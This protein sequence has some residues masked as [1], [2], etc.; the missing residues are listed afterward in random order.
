M[1]KLLVFVS[2]Y[3]KPQWRL[4]VIALLTGLIAASASGLGIPLMF[5]VVFP[6]IFTGIEMLP[7]AIQPY[8]E[9]RSEQQILLGTCLLM[10]AVFILRGL[11][12]W[13][14]SIVVN[15]LA[16]RVLT[17]MRMSFFTRLHHLPIA[18]FEGYQKGD[19]ISRVVGDAA[20]VQI[21]MTTISNDIVKQPITCL[22]ALVAFFSLLISQGADWTFALNIFFVA[23]ALYPIISFGRRIAARSHKAQA[24]IGNLN[25]LVQQN[26]EMQREVRAY[27]MESQQVADFERVSDRYATNILKLVKYQKALL[28][29]METVT[30]LALAFLLV[31][32]KLAGMNYYDFMALAAALFF[33]FDSMKKTGRSF[34][35]FNEAQG[36]IARLSELLELPN[37]MPEPE[38]PLEM[39]DVRGDIDFKNASF[40]YATGEVALR[41]V[42][43][44]IPAGQIVGLVGPSGA[45]KTTFASLIPRFYDITEGSL[46]VDGVDVREVTQHQLRENIALVGQHA[47]LFSGTIRENIGLGR[48]GCSDA[49]IMAAAQASSVMSF[50]N[51]MPL[52][53]DTQLG[54]AGAG[55]SGGQRQR[56]AIARAFIKDAPILILDEATSALD[57]KS[58]QEI[59]VELNRLAQGR[60]TLIVAHRFSTI[61]MAHRILVFDQGSIVGDG[62]H[63][64]LYEGC[65]LYRELYD[66]QGL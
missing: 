27:A 46:C 43:L 5:A 47:M 17:S 39:K 61:A 10:P 65:P 66:K 12:M 58:E 53:L 9:G 11:A 4:F 55:L 14:N 3:L 57:S 1:S 64:E 21:I 25:S 44:H 29:V 33:A 2:L 18:L 15:L 37:D 8:L 52:G 54:N 62:T 48:E 42:N 60:T 20:K 35:R 63:D 36:A 38:S 30:A 51:Q 26:L 28:P 34:N 6:V 7:H 49:Q 32:G 41:D 56:V 45:G 22:C 40:A 50:A 13:G 23:L 19:L 16:I 59:Q 31:R 24:D